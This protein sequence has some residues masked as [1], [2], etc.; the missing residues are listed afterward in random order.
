MA[1][2]NPLGGCVSV[3]F[4]AISITILV[5]T[6]RI[7][8]YTQENPLE[9]QLESGETWDQYFTKAVQAESS[10]LKKQCK[11]GDEIV[12]DFCT[13][14]QKLSGCSEIT[15][16]SL[17]NNKQFLRYLLAQSECDNYKNKI[18]ALK[19]KETLSQVF[20]L[21]FDM[22]HKMALGLLILVVI[23]L[24]VLVVTIVAV[25]GTVCCGDCA[26]II[27][28]PFLPVIFLFVIGSG[29]ANLVLFII[30]SVNYYNGDTSTY[31]EFLECSGVN[32][33]KFHDKF[34]V[35]EDL[36]SVFVPFFVLNI[37]YIILG[38]ANSAVNKKD[39]NGSSE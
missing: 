39:N 37:I 21:N 29:I 25:L 31:V 14:E 2:S 28:L 38:W 33:G 7:Y 8:N 15:A 13:E 24:G 34:G 10:Y 3:I 32:T 20:T 5:Y 23:G 26:L 17:K 18:L 4:F 27:L 12:N 11:C 30:L 1:D 22:I 35:V 6:I 19:E 16:N 36:K 9:K